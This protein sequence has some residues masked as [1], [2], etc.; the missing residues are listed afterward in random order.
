[1]REYYEYEALD[2]G[3]TRRTN[4]ISEAFHILVD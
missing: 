4:S 3:A 2:I 1:L